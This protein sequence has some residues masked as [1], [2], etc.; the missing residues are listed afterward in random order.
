MG[1]SLAA[2][3]LGRA[4]WPDTVAPA[5]VD[6][7]V[8]KRN[9]V[10]VWI[11]TEGSQP[12]LYERCVK[13]G[14]P[15]THIR[16]PLDPKQEG[17]ATPS[18]KLDDDRQWGIF[19]QYIDAWRPKLVIVDSLSGAV[20]GDENSSDMRFVLQRLAELARDFQTAVVA[21][22]HAK[23]SQGLVVARVIEDM[24]RLR[25]SSTIAQFA[26]SII[27]I[28]QP[29][30]D[31][32]RLRVR[33]IK[34]NLAQVPE[35]LGAVIDGDSMWFDSTPPETP[36]KPSTKSDAW[37]FLVD[38]LQ[39]GKRT[40]SDIEEEAKGRGISISAM[41]RVSTDLQIRKDK[42]GHRGEWW[43]TLPERYIKQH[44]NG[45]ARHGERDE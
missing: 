28:D 11:D 9:D 10:V 16:W 21:I 8:D 27:A 19:V 34:S 3:A 39:N 5:K 17:N 4:P 29:S 41:R 33:V 22:H 25:G 43:W 6:E 30:E 26:R 1:L 12:M 2:S 15:R 36:R 38:A 13:R 24:D 18:W 44:T 45:N 14:L 7:L 32:T 42:I 35:P 23:K 20:Q 37:E 40:Y 31:D